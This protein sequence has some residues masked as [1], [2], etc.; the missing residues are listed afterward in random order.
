MSDKIS[1]GHAYKYNILTSYYWAPEGTAAMQNAVTLGRLKKFHS[2]MK[3]SRLNAVPNSQIFSLG[4][5]LLHLCLLRP[6]YQ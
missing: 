1:K 4:M 6:L 2:G 3:T 5:T